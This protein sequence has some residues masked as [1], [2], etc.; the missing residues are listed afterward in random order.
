MSQSNNQEDYL[1]SIMLSNN[2]SI[3]KYR[4]FV[5]KKNKEE[6]ANF[7][8]ERFSER[9]ITP[10]ENIPKNKNNGFCIMANCCLMIEALESF[11]QGWK[12]TRNRSELAFCKFFD[13]VKL[14]S[15]FH[16]Y[17]S[18][19]YR[20]VRCGILHQ[21]ETTGGWKIRRNGP[22]FDQG[23]LTINAAKFLKSLKKYLEEYCE[24]LK[25]AD[26]NNE[27]WKNLRTK[28]DALIDNCKRS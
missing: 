11:Y 3:K 14:F 1:N 20:N 25:S 2:V 4:N 18:P 12:A 27:R 24:W 15:D 16:G 10:I 19:F 9:Y 7:I 13:R 28:M 23:Q 26:W 21:A 6:I 22:L 17:T 5:E 8:H